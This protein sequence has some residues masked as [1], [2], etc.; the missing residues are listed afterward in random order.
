VCWACVVLA[1]CGSSPLAPSTFEP[2][3]LGP[4]VAYLEADPWVHPLLGETLGPWVR[5]Q[6]S[7]V[8]IYLDPT[9]PAD[10]GARASLTSRELFWPPRNTD[11]SLTV[12]AAALIHEA[13]HFEGYLHTCGTAG[14]QGDKTMEERGAFAIQIVYLEHKGEP[15]LADWLRR[16]YIG[17]H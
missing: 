16:N 1:G 2:A 5:R 7:S 11:L 4:V 15:S 6:L 14:L 10:V 9:L 17:C 8:R 3:D 12:Q 13:R